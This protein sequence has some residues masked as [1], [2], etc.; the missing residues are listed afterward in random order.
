MG[1]VLGEAAHA[2]QA[3]QHAGALVAIDGAPLGQTHRQVAVAAQVTLV[4]QDVERAVHGL[5]VVVL[6]V[7]L[8]RRIHVLFV[9]A[10]VAAGL[11]QPRAT[12]VRRVDQLVAVGQVLVPAELLGQMAH[13][14]ALGMPETSPPPIS[15]WMLKRSRSL[16]RRRWSRFS[17]SARRH[18]W[19]SSSFW[20]AKATP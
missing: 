6:L 3:V 12:D 19:S 5:D 16:P 14:A 13:H 10:E 8:H 9:E 17:A 4:D 7:D 11:P 20:S 18:R 2:H 1:I 15:W